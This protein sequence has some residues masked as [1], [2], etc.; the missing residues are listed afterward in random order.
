MGWKKFLTDLRAISQR[1]PNWPSHL[2]NYFLW[3][4]YKIYD[5]TGKVTVWL[6]L[7][8]SHSR[9]L[10][11]CSQLILTMSSSWWNCHRVILSFARIWGL[12]NKFIRRKCD[13]NKGLPKSLFNV[14][15]AVAW[16][17]PLVLTVSTAFFA[18]PSKTLNK[19]IICILSSKVLLQCTHE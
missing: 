1:W 12:S 8:N 17:M 6:L 11:L 13:I 9:K 18:S 3:W 4:I 7:L 5:I 2:S 14:F 19:G 15:N 10:V 16:N